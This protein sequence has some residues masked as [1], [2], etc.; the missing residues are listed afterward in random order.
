MDIFQNQIQKAN[1]NI[2]RRA[3]DS[4]TYSIQHV[5]TSS[6]ASIQYTFKNDFLI[7]TIFKI[8]SASVKNV[9]N[10]INTDS[11]I[12]GEKLNRLGDNYYSILSG[13]PTQ[14]KSSAHAAYILNSTIKLM[15]NIFD[16]LSIVLKHSDDCYLLRVD[17]SVF[18]SISNQQPPDDLRPFDMLFRLDDSQCPKKIMTLI[19]DEKNE[20]EFFFYE[21]DYTPG[22]DIQDY[23][24]K[25][26]NY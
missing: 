8:E 11:L 7:S 2:I 18:E 10:F 19:P 26:V 17:K 14:V 25:V 9:S 20:N 12:S 23:I 13:E 5:Q 24:T 1:Y 21:E 4:L 15:Q 22:V 16:S 3:N 6:E